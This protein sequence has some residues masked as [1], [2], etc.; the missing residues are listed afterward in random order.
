MNLG[1][2][3]NTRARRLLEVVFHSTCSLQTVVETKYGASLDHS[4]QELLF[5]PSA[6]PE[7]Y[8]GLGGSADKFGNQTNCH[9]RCGF[10]RDDA[11][12]YTHFFDA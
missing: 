3:L 7:R 4:E 12:M 8:R 11:V 2:K 9:G 6:W 1:D 10:G 5:A